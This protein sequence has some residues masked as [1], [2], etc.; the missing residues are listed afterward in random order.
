[1]LFGNPMQLTLYDAQT[2]MAPP[3]TCSE[4]GKPRPPTGPGYCNK[5]C[6]SASYI[7]KLH[8]LRERADRAVTMLRSRNFDDTA[9]LIEELRAYVR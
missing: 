5:F 9:D 7:R 3:R 1:M 6:E 4:C 8:D 2:A